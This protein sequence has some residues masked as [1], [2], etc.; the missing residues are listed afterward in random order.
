MYT[1]VSMLMGACALEPPPRRSEQEQGV[2]TA[3][4][5]HSTPED[6]NG[7]PGGV[8]WSPPAHTPEMFLTLVGPAFVGRGWGEAALLA[9]WQTLVP[10]AVIWE[11]N[12][13][14]RSPPRLPQGR[15]NQLLGNQRSFHLNL[16]RVLFGSEHRYPP[17]NL[18][19]PATPASV[20]TPQMERRRCAGTEKQTDQIPRLPGTWKRARAHFWRDR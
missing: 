7:I 17:R 18:G 12:P 13:S 16:F 6:T 15:K 10:S 20:L 1:N 14:G 4:L 9:V 2:P 5:S 19:C 8:G 3:K 11:T